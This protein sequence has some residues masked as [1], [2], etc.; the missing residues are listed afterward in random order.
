M[1]KKQSLYLFGVMVFCL[2]FLK[3]C[4]IAFDRQ[5]QIDF[6]E[7]L[8]WQSQGHP[9]TCNPATYGIKE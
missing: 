9:I 1:L 5:A 3:A 8:S 7:C 2:V 6:Y 4:A